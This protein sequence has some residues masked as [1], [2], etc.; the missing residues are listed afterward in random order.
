MFGRYLI[1][2][3]AAALAVL[4]AHQPLV[5]LLNSMGLI[6]FKAYNM[7]AVKTAPT[8][9]AAVMA[10][11]GFKGW[12]GIFNQMFWGGL[13]GVVFAGIHQWLPGRAML[14]KGILF[15]LIILVASNWIV[16]PL[17]RGTPLFANLVPMS[18][19]IGVLLQCTFGAV[20][21]LLY[22]MFRRT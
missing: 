4:V 18:M 10:Q 19:L 5:F 9:L 17:I 15:G 16:L 6:P 3:L 22:S 21:A 12:P 11:A 13:W 14:V 7:E 8:W 20:T 2:F 1:G